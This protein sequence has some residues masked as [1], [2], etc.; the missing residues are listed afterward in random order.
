MDP[1]RNL[2]GHWAASTIRAMLQNPAYTG[3]TVWNRLNFTEAKHAGGGARRRAKEEWVIAEEAH[4]P[5]VTDATFEAAQRR[6]STKGRGNGSAHSKNGYV[7]SG[8]VRCCC[9]D[10]PMAM[11]GK[12]RKGHT[13]Y[14]CEYAASYGDTAALEAH[15]DQKFISAR[16]DGLLRLVLRFFEQRIFGPLRLERLEKQLRA[17]ARSQRQNGKL[18]GTKLRQR[19]AEIERRVKAQVQALENG[20]EPELVSERIAELRADKEALEETLAEVGAER[21]EAED[22]E[23]A[24][25]LEKLPDLSKALVE[26]P[27]EVQRQVFEAFELQIAYDKV[28]RR[29]E[30]SATVSEAVADA[31]ENTKA[32]RKEGSAVVVRDIAGARFVSRDHPRIVE[33]MAA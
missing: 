26:A 32:L 19:I 17:E 33:R 13:Y 22:E 28:G 6:F 3:R 31:F 14:V 5:L 1:S 16:E 11:A 30:L 24:T 21:E 29:I 2:R 18:A 20:I 7:L 10:G 25:Q 4:L 9:G 23:L 8:M 12:R 27:P 15:G